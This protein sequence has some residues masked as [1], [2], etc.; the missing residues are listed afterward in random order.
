MITTEI[1]ATAEELEAKFYASSFRFSYSSLNKLMNAP[2]SFY[3]E[4]ILK[5]KDDEE[6]R[7]L[8]RGK[9]IHYLILDNGLFDDYYILAPSGVPTATTKDVVDAVARHHIELAENGEAKGNTLDDYT[10]AVLDVLVDID[11]YQG[12][13]DDPK[14]PFKTG[15]EKRLEKIVTEQ[16]KEYFEFLITKGDREIIDPSVLDECT[17]AADAVKNDKKLRELLGLD[18]D[19]T[20]PNYKVFNEVHLKMDDISKLGGITQF[21]I[22]GFLDNMVVDLENK[23]VRINDVKSTGKSLTKFEESV[24]Y[25]NYWLQAGIY[26]ILA[27]NFIKNEV[28]SS[29]TNWEDFKFEFRF[30]VVDKYNQVYAFKLKPETM[31]KCI[32]EAAKCLKKGAYHYEQRDYT[33]PYDFVAGEVEL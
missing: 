7:H 23:V 12:L 8:T 13:K 10:D 19:P 2:R 29:D 6:M 5:E 33:L 25:W 1:Q 18:I 14:H 16:A 20:D 31:S 3:K 11:K 9:M 24:E 28:E 26:W 30:V 27:T 4:Y 22:H 15:D 32:N 17:V 21:G